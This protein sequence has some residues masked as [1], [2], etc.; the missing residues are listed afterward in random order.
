[1]IKDHIVKL[2]QHIYKQKHP[3]FSPIYYSVFDA[4]FQLRIF[5]TLCETEL[6]KTRII[7]RRRQLI[8][9]SLPLL[10]VAAKRK[11]NYLDTYS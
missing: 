7:K 6:S 2:I 10:Y 3:R 1:M 9:S 11:R 4:L 8:T 5:F